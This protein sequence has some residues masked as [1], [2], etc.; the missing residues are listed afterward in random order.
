MIFTN[1]EQIRDFVAANV[2]ITIDTLK[3]HIAP[4][5]REYLQ[6]PWLGF[7]LMKEIEMIANG[8]GSGEGEE[9][10]SLDDELVKLAR[11]VVA[12]FTFLKAVPFLELNIGDNGIVR[13]ESE[14][15]KTAYRGQIARIENSFK[16]SGWNALE[17]LLLF[18]DKYKASYPLWLEA[19]G[20]IEHTRYFFS[21]SV[22]FCRYFPLKF[23]RVTYQSLLPAMR[24]VE[25]HFLAPSIG[26]SQLA[27]LL[28]KS[29]TGEG[30]AN[31]KKALEYIKTAIAF[32][33][34]ARSVT[35]NWVEITPEGAKFTEKISGLKDNVDHV[36]TATADVLSTVTKQHNNTADDY[37][38]QAL[39]LMIDNPLD[40]PIFTSS[41]Q[42]QAVTVSK[43]RGVG[44]T[45]MA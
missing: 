25:L 24:W 39:S 18:L 16:E 44:K 40:F 1:V 3:P 8:G 14:H 30:S 36:T 22:D 26:A 37:L 34:I 15:S 13:T 20:Y 33:S 21:G 4:A 28:V 5:Q 11:E 6:N 41:N 2:N 17:N 32:K 7:L 45:W 10:S 27:D 29:K 35:E 42:A 43:G 38:Q 31:E 9:G 19:P 23:G 12:N